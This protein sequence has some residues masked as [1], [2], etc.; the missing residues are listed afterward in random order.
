[1]R[2]YKRK[3][4][5]RKA[6]SQ[7]EAGVHG[8]H[9]AIS[10]ASPFAGLRV[11]SAL[12][13]EANTSAKSKIAA[14]I[15]VLKCEHQASVTAN[16]LFHRS[17]TPLNKWFLAVFL[18]VQDKRGISAAKLDR[19]IEVSSPTAWLML[20][21]LRKAMVDQD[22]AYLLSRIVERDDAYFGAPDEGEKRGRGTDK[23]PGAIAVQVDELG[24]PGYVKLMGV[25]N[26]RSE[27]LVEAAQKTIQPDTDLRTDGYKA[28]IVFRNTA[29]K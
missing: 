19:D 17:H 6:A 23:T 25:E 2:S 26:L 3:R 14:C 24:C 11:S 8:I 4:N 27:T 15:T 22:A 29:T 1:M 5:R 9:E 10:N 18:T 13:A 12:A 16:T 20:H 28:I 7:D 21:K